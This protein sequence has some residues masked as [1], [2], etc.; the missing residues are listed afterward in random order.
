M[1]GDCQSLI[2]TLTAVQDTALAEAARRESDWCEDGTLGETLHRPAGSC[3]TPPTSPRRCSG[4]RTRRRSAGSSWRCAWPSP[5]NPCRPTAAPLPTPT[6]WVGCTPRWPRAGST[7]TGR[8]SSSTSSRSPRPRSPRRSCPPS[9][10]TCT[11]TP[12]PCAGA[13]GGWSRASR[14][15]CCASAPSG[16]GP[17]PGCAAG[18]RSRASTPGSARSP[19]RM[20]RPPGPRS[21]GSRTTWSPTAPARTSSRP[22]AGRSPTSSSATRRS[23]C[24][25]C[26]PSRPTARRRVPTASDAADCDIAM[27]PTT[28]SGVVA[29]VRPPQGAA[30][31][32][33]NGIRPR[34]TAATTWCRCR[35]PDRPS[36]CSCVGTGSATTSRRSHRRRGS[37]ARRR[38]R[39]SC[40][41]TRSPAP[42]STPTTTS[43]PTPTD[44][45]RARGA[46]PRPRRPVPLPRVQRGSP[47]LRPRPRAAL[48]DRTHRGRQPAHPVPTAPPHQA[49]TRLAG[50]PGTRRH[51]H[52]DRP[53]RPR[54]HDRAPR[55]PGDGA[56][57]VRPGGGRGVRR[58][59]DDRPRH[60]AAIDDDASATAWS[61]LETV[62]A[63]RLEH[64]R[65]SVSHQRESPPLHSAADAPRRFRPATGP[66]HRCPTS[67]PSDAPGADP[68]RRHRAGAAP[69]GLATNLSA[70][71]PPP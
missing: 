65:A 61:A 2:N 53:G 64:H 3:S 13:P 54:S 41:A 34:P 7:A 47:L 17:R 15:T 50:A 40:R 44:R 26:S 67:R 12:P 32:S 31:A 68:S 23:T 57:P 30:A 55:R 58:R 16:R 35:E 18:S 48:A 8:A 11:T 56:A 69:E 20:P 36:P 10:T 29:G 33:S 63:I 70:R 66:A 4:R 19:A 25:S 49:A 43:R 22:A 39:R 37:D 1:A 14:P 5:A 6:G 28:V 71:R 21:T 38:G 46:G 51:R 42:A 52:L 27:R 60:P 45:A 62:L 9:T 24:R 59:R